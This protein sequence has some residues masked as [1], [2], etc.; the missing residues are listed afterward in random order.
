MLPP[1]AL[2]FAVTANLERIGRQWRRLARET[3][4]SHGISQACGLPLISIGRLGE[5]LRQGALAE[6]VGMEGPS[7]VRLL[8]QLA[9]AGLVE[10]R[11]DPSDRRAKT[12]W[13]TDKGRAITGRIEADLAA[14]RAKVFADVPSADLEA[15][16]RVFAT[17]ERAGA[18]ATDSEANA[19]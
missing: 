12:L 8:D 5:G 10:R 7:L 19:A 11:D 14:L 3:V 16:L 1:A 18:L 13:L 17:I 15:V 4:E 2:R 9:A 6:E